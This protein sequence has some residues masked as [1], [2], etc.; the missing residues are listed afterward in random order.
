MDVLALAV[1]A[2]LLVVG[3]A[4]AVVRHWSASAACIGVG[5]VLPLMAYA[6]GF[7]AP[8]LL[9]TLTLLAAPLAAP[10]VGWG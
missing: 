7:D 3:V 6:D 2:A 10:F 4:A 5:G 8:V 9:A 1:A